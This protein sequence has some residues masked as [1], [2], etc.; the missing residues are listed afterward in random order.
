MSCKPN[1]CV[2]GYLVSDI[3]DIKATAWQ[4]ALLQTLRQ[5]RDKAKLAYLPK[6]QTIVP[7]KF[8][9]NCGRNLDYFHKLNPIK[10]VIAMATKGNLIGGGA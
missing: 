10:D 6:Q 3:V 5:D 8:C 1:E 2:V 4:S 9:P 7:L